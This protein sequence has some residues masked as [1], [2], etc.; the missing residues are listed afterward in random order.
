MCVA[1]SVPL[2]LTTVIICIRSFTLPINN[3]KVD[4]TEGVKGKGKHDDEESVSD[5]DSHQL[6]YDS[7]S[8]GD[9]S[10]E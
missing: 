8:D 7:Q 4:D 2:S 3:I 10:T 1:V 9:F 5:C 6:D